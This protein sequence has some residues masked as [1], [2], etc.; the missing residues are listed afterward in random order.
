MSAPRS[1]SVLIVDDEP[2]ARRGVRARLAR[3]GGVEVVGECG[4]G[5]EA[6]EAIRAVDEDDQPIDLVFLD[7]QMPGL[8][9]FGV[10]EAIGPGAMPVVVFVTAYDEHALRAFEAEALDYLLKPIDDDRLRR[11]VD[12]AIDRVHDR[13]RGERSE[14]LRFAVRGGGRVRY[15]DAQDVVYVEAAGDYVV[16]HAADGSHLLRATME[17][18]GRDLEGEGF[19]RVHRSTLARASSVREVRSDGSGGGTA[20]LEDGTELRVSRGCWAVALSDL[21]GRSSG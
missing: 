4:S 21:G 20:V 3:I 10:V 17:A 9:G 11:A 2:L 18:V 19:V 16:L 15:I 8:D 1:L 6:V 12:R 14:P 13:R 7:V 5:R